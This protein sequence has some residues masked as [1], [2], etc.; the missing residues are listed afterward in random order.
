MEHG[1]QIRQSWVGPEEVH[2]KTIA[3]VTFVAVLAVGTARGE[4][5]C[6]ADVEKLCAGIPPGGGKLHACL[7]ANEAKVSPECKAQLA[8]VAHKVKEVGAACA[9]DIQSICPDV[10]PGGGAVLACLKT[11]LFSVTAGCRDVI[12][13]AQ[14]KVAEFKKACG[15]DARTFCKGITPGD[16]RVW[17]CLKSKEAELSPPCRTLMGE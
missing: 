6:R 12:R 11:N 3:R 1:R 4:D 14:E 17:A 7:R 16:G 8:S 13:G 15:K 10:Q 9:D 2:M 5:A